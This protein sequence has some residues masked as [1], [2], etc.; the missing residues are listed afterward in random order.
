MAGN[1]P[2][3]FA[4][5]VLAMSMDY[6][7]RAYAFPGRGVTYWTD[8]Q[9]DLADVLQISTA[10]GVGTFGALSGSE[11]LMSLMLGALTSQGYTKF[12]ADK[13]GLPRY[14]IAREAVPL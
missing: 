11:M 13:F 1:I 8:P 14:I 6:I 4:G 10:L 9:L 2:Y 3:V 12:A 5:F 7:G